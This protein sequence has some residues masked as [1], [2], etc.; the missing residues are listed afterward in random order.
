M[1][2]LPDLSERETLGTAYFTAS[3]AGTL[4]VY[5]G[6]SAQWQDTELAVDA[7][8]WVRFDVRLDYVSKTWDIWVEGNE[9]ATGLGFANTAIT[10]FARVRFE[11]LR[12]TE[13]QGFI[14][15]LSISTAMPVSLSP[16]PHVSD[17]WKQQIVDA[18]P[19]DAITAPSQV[20][21]GDDFDGDGRTNE[22]EFRQGTSPTMADADVQFYVSGDTGNDMNYN[23][24]SLYPGQPTSL[25][26][27]KATLSGALAAAPDGSRILIEAATVSYD[28]STLSLAGKNLTLCPHG[29]VVLK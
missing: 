6:V 1:A 12:A 2:E 11:Q 25:H 9:I 16:W 17:A 13:A 7:A 5:D 15:S 28:E 8:S 3:E 29:D 26:G 10:A 19:N 20:L 27:P 22:E 18:D 21:A 4:C 24:L 14:D 23:G